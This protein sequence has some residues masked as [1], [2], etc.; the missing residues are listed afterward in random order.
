MRT[1][2]MLSSNNMLATVPTWIRAVS[3][4]HTYTNAPWIIAHIKK[5]LQ[6]TRD[7]LSTNVA[8]R[9]AIARVSMRTLPMVSPAKVL[10]TG[11]AWICTVSYPHTH[12]HA[13]CTLLTQPKS[14]LSAGCLGMC[15]PQTS[16]HSTGQCVPI[17]PGELR[18]G[19][20]CWCGADVHTLPARARTFMN[21][22]HH[23]K[24]KK[25]I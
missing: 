9:A 11:V 23:Q 18:H 21:Q 12:R 17:A 25:S 14:H 4:S 15:N 1:L 10:G 3:Y 20:R 8:K 2:P 6:L 16:W 19:A 7:V 22:A 5:K 24:V 13:R